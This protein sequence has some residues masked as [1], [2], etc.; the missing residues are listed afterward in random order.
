MRRTS[1]Y[2]M[3]EC[4]SYNSSK[5]LTSLRRSCC[6]SVAS[7]DTSS[8]PLGEKTARNTFTLLRL[9]QNYTRNLSNWMYGGAAIFARIQTSV[10]FM[11]TWP[12]LRAP[13]PL[14]SPVLRNSQSPAHGN[15]CRQETT[16][17]G[18]RVISRAPAGVLHG[19]CCIAAVLVDKSEHAKTPARHECEEPAQPPD[20]PAQPGPRSRVPRHRD[21]SLPQQ[22]W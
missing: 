6:I 11:Q 16:P 3:R 2:T 19:P 21:R 13:P 7:G 18:R 4:R 8:L 5:A 14:P 17:A 20:A 15:N 12:W 1:E 10:E 22:N 9:L